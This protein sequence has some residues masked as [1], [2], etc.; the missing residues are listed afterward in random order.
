MLYTLLQHKSKTELR[1]PFALARILGH[2]LRLIKNH[3]GCRDH[4]AAELWLVLDLHMGAV[5]CK[6]VT[7]L[8]KEE[9]LLIKK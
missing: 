3:S 5:T 7:A 1:S 2:K 8:H 9:H 6:C 4:G